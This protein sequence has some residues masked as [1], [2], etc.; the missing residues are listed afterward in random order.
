MEIAGGEVQRAEPAF[1]VV[2]SS[3]EEGCCT[4][5]ARCPRMNFFCDE[6][7][8][9]AWHVTSPQERGTR[10]SLGDAVEAGKA[11]FGSLLT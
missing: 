10:L 9:R 2:W 7:H 3:E 6:A 5:E 1:V 8:L 11:A 4:A